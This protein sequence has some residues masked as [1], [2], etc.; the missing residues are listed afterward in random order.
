MKPRDLEQKPPPGK[1]PKGAECLLAAWRL[2]ENGR[3]F[4]HAYTYGPLCKDAMRG[5][6]EFTLY[7]DD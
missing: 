7:W 1:L 3:W 2:D 4:L 5:G 6:G